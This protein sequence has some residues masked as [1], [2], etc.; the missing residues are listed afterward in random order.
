MDDNIQNDQQN[1][2][3]TPNQEYP[4][5][6]SNQQDSTSTEQALETS[7][8]AQDQIFD[9]QQQE[10]QNPE[11]QQPVVPPANYD[12]AKSVLIFFGIL[13]VLLALFISNGCNNQSQSEA[14]W[15][16][17][18]IAP[19]LFLVFLCAIII[20]IVKGMKK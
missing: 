16:G 11:Q 18:S 6:D 17:V 19:I 13:F 1:T 2:D 3:P 14:I 15:V 7:P 10:N 12:A 5:Q 9:P 8:E 20:A 4:T